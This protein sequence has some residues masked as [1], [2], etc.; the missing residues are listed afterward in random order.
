MLVRIPIVS[1][2]KSGLPISRTMAS[3]VPERREV[4]HAVQLLEPAPLARRAAR[5]G[6]APSVP[7]QG[8]GQPL[9]C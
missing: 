4:I 3:R 2:D 5:E 6:G 9:S 7:D 1:L 8:S